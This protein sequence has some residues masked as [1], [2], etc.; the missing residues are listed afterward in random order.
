[1]KTADLAN[2]T[3]GT[4]KKKTNWGKSLLVQRKQIE[5]N[6]CPISV[7]QKK[8]W[9]KTL[10]MQGFHFIYFFWQNRY[11]S[12]DFNLCSEDFAPARAILPFWYNFL[13]IYRLSFLGKKLPFWLWTRVL[14]IF[15]NLNMSSRGFS[16]FSFQLWKPLRI[17]YME[18]TSEQLLNVSC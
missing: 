7:F 18:K 11:F 14:I 13:L 10:P 3:T 6:R 16:L 4:I 5:G 15:T 8:N 2:N 17:L 9:E 1:M 12:S